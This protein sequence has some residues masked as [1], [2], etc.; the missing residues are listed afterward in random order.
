MCGRGDWE[1]VCVQD[2]DLNIN[3]EGQ[4][5]HQPIGGHC[6]VCGGADIG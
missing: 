6:C 3:I 5:Q 1:G 4:Q 2:C